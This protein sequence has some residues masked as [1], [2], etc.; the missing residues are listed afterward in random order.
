MVDLCNWWLYFV[1]II[2]LLIFLF[3][4]AR[5]KQYD[6]GIEIE[7]MIQDFDP[8]I[9]VPDVN[10]IMK[11]KVHY[12]ENNWKKW[13]KKILKNLQNC[14]ELGLLKNKGREIWQK[15]IKKI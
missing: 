8:S 7:E 1:V 6:D 9:E 3:I 2:V 5:R 11:R 14:Y 4:R 10:E 13:Q 15:K 12:E